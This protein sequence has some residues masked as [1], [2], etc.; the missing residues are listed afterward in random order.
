MN[1]SYTGTSRV[2]DHV[3]TSNLSSYMAS[4][5]RLYK[6]VRVAYYGTRDVM[7]SDC[8]LHEIWKLL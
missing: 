8:T 6:Q 3:V 5:Q 2:L 7:I 4:D 1:H